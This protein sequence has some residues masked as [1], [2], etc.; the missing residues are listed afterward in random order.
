[1]LKKREKNIYIPTRLIWT[2]LRTP[3]TPEDTKTISETSEEDLLER[4][5]KENY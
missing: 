4:A 3:V 1:M 5:V 2:D